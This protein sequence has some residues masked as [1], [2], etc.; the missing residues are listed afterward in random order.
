MHNVHVQR[1]RATPKTLL[2]LA[3]VK[4]WPASLGLAW[5]GELTW[6]DPDLKF[7]QKVWKIP[8]GNYWNFGGAARRRFW[9]IWEKPQVGFQ[10]PRHG[11]G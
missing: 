10:P 9:V 7:W 3:G 4:V 6:P 8:G 5:P 1:F 2:I 11:A